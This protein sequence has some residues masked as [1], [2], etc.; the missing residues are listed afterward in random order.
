MYNK[1]LNFDDLACGFSP[2]YADW[3]GIAVLSAQKKRPAPACSPP[4]NSTSLTFIMGHLNPPQLETLQTNSDWWNNGPLVEWAFLIYLR[5]LNTTNTADCTV[6]R[7]KKKRHRHQWVFS[8]LQLTFWLASFFFRRFLFF[9][10]TTP[11]HLTLKKH[12]LW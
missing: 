1:C 11:R 12:Q 8:L 4:R 6:G 7:M 10:H 5:D 9:G 3:I 2:R